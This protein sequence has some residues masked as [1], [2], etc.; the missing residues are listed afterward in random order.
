LGGKNYAS[1]G[2]WLNFLTH[3]Y[4]RKLQWAKSFKTRKA[5]GRRQR[6][7]IELPKILHVDDEAD[8][9]E[10]ARLALETV[11]GVE[12][13]QCASGC[14]ALEV[15]P[16]H[17]P[18]LFLLDLMMP[19]MDGI[20]T[21]KK[22]REMPAFDRTPAFFMTA[23]ASDKDERVLRHNGAAAVIAKPFDPLCLADDIVRM[24]RNLRAQKQDFEKVAS[25]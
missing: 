15:A 25:V 1:V 14:E 2:S 8:I 3:A 18:D 12:L 4:C 13:V 21:L 24:W 7:E 16:E 6:M 17:L 9:R 19:D 11:G 10:I 5:L 22:L 20:Q 23:R